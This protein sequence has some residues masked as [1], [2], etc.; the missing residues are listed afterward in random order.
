[1]A[2]AA[3]AVSGDRGAMSLGCSEVRVFL[4]CTMGRPKGHLVAETKLRA[5]VALRSSMGL[6]SERPQET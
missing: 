1:M 4:P 3:C 6:R 2:G 5:Q